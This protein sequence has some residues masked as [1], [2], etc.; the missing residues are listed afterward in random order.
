[1]TIIDVTGRYP[2]ASVWWRG[3]YSSADITDITL[4]HTAMGELPSTASEDDELAVLDCIYAFHVNTRGFGGIGYHG[5]GFPSSRAYLTSPMTR[6]G[7][8]VADENNHL[9][10]FA[11][12]GNH[13][14]SIPSQGTLEALAELIANADGMKGTELPLR[15]HLYWGGTTCP[16]N[17]WQEWVP[18]LRDYIQEEEMPLSQGDLDLIARVFRKESDSYVL[19]K[20]KRIV[21]AQIE[22]QVPAIVRE[23]IDKSKI[24]S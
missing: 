14:N 23:E 13:T 6:W 20:V 21:M 7:A 5:V 22:A 2:L 16:G 11:A 8:H 18:Q 24:T 3:I 15:P 1:M 17:R 12:A 9:W 19:P 10:G 4:H